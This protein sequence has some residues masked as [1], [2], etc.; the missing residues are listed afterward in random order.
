VSRERPG[1]AAGTMPEASPRKSD[2]MER[3]F[4][5]DLDALNE[6]FPWLDEFFTSE[7]IG[8]HDAFA[9]RLAVEELFAN[10]VRHNIGGRD[11]VTIRLDVDDECLVVRLA[12][13]DVEPFD[14]DSIRPVDVD[15]PLA[16]RRV[17]GLGV[18]FVRR[19]FDDLSYDY[20]DRT[21]SVTATKNLET[22]D[23]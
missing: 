1:Q 8:T 7:G 18:H 11:H 2:Q 17:G 23:V 14:V 9:T 5:R 13:F 22:K 16:S 3:A 15:L 12:D 6:V 4:R 21:L 10:F 20:R 19:M